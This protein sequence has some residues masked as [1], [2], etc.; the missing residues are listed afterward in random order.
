[1]KGFWKKLLTVAAISGAAYVGVKGYKKVTSIVK[2]SKS[3]PDYLENMLD[4][5]PKIS[6]S[7]ALKSLKISVGITQVAFDKEV[8]LV[9]HIKEYVEDFYPSLSCLSIEVNTYVKSE[10][11]VDDD[12]ED[13]CCCSNDDCC[14]NEEEKPEE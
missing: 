2:L 13:E 10:E 12:D 14:C 3:L 4:E 11:P 1:M 9:T 7:M 8:D 5:K 6:I